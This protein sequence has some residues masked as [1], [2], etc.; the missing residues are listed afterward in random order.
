MGGGE[1]GLTLVLALVVFLIVQVEGLRIPRMLKRILLA[2]LVLRVVGSGARYWILYDFYRGNGDAGLY[3]TWGI[4]YADAFWAGDFS[5]LTDPAQWRGVKWYGTQF[6]NFVAGFVTMGL[7]PTQFGTF[8][9]FSLLAFLGMAGFALAFRRSFP[10]VDPRWYWGLIFLF[11]S[12]WFWPSSIGKEA[13]SMM[14][15]GLATLGFVGR[16]NEYIH[17]PLLAVG[18]F[19]VFAIRPQVAAV[20]ITSMMLAHWLGSTGRMTFSKLVQGAVLLIVGVGGVIVSARYMGIESFDMEG[21]VA[22]MEENTARSEGGSQ[23][24]T[25]GVGVGNIPVA[26]LNTIA[27]PFVWEASNPTMLMAALEVVLF[28]GLVVY[29]RREV[30][31]TLRRWRANRL[32]RL[33]LPFALLYSVSL[34]MLIANLGIIARQRVLML[35]FLFLV[36][37]AAPVGV[38]R[39]ASRRGRTPG[40]RGAPDPQPAGVGR[41]G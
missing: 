26:L 32:L 13:I 16:R 5:A 25:V 33:A 15:L 30:M 41:S 18:L 38:G 28:W 31:W 35:P 29:R 12:L 22:Y 19:F 17:W 24:E 7:G 6:V 3:Y 8:V 4:R 34:G 20:F 40:P 21:V 1:F 37:A 27:R 9:A 36:L 39:P 2:A 14:G 11:P 23:I 10:R